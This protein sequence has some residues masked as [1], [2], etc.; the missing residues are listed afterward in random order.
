MSI[1]SKKG[2]T[3]EPGV[4]A[5]NHGGDKKDSGMPVSAN[6]P[7]PFLRGLVAQ[8]KLADGT[9]PLEKLTDVVVQ[10]A[11]SGEGQ[12][13]LGAKLISLVALVANG[14]S[15][16]TLL[17]TKR[18]G[19]RLNE[20]RDGPL[21][22]KGVGS[23]VLDQHGKVS[24]SQLERLKEFA[25]QKQAHD[26]TSE[27]GLEQAELTSFM[28]AN[29]ARAKG[30]RRFIDRSL[31]NGEWPV[32]LQVMGKEG[33]NGRYLSIRDVEVLLIEH[34]FPPHMRANNSD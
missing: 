8:G 14:I 28:D 11:R 18:Y 30:N 6:N 9:V 23:G 2:R 1:E 5:E 31:M 16:F 29:F 34:R 13:E 10:A 27:L 3:D 15:P 4:T 22:K 21:N 32:L 20:L 7:C 24:H 33:P 19:V 26:G 12:P 17:R 25:Q